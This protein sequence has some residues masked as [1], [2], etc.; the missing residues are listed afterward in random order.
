MFSVPPAIGLYRS[1]PQIEKFEKFMRACNVEF[2]V[3]GSR[4]PSLVAR[5]VEINSG[6]E[7]EK[8]DGG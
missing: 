6:Y 7:P 2:S 5:L 4:A 3:S 1:E 8:V